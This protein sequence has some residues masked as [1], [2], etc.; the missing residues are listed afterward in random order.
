MRYKLIDLL[1]SMESPREVY[2]ISEAA[3]IRT[4]K[5]ER[6]ALIRLTFE[7]DAYFTAELT[8]LGLA[9]LEYLTAK[10]VVVG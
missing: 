6:T 2:D 8:P 3:R 10:S 5:S 4:L 9:Y 7:T 1:Q